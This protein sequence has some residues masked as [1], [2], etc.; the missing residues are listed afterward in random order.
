[1]AIPRA[2][3][4]EGEMSEVRNK[5]EDRPSGRT[6]D[7]LVPEV[8]T[9]VVTSP[10]PGTASFVEYIIEGHPRVD[11]QNVAAIIH[12]MADGKGTVTPW[13]RR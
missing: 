11:Q 6:N 3:V 5:S 13:R 12:L 9:L 8:P 7:P 2:L 1:M 10:S 4:G